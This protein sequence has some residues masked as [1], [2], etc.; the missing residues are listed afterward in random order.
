MLKRA[1]DIAVSG[2]ALV[3]LA[4][5]MLA[6]SIA[7][8]LESPGGAIFRQ[9]RAGWRGRPFT[10]LKFRTMR[11]DVDPYGHSPHSGDDPRLTRIGKWLRERSLDELPQLWNVLRG[12]MSLVG[13]RPLYE[14]QA[15]EWTPEQRRRLDVRPG[16]TG[17]AQAYGRAS[18]PIEDKI[19]MDLH[20][21]DNASFPMDLR[22]L[23]ATAL[24]AVGGEG[25][26]YEQQYSRQ[27]EYENERE[28]TPDDV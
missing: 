15:A 6:I 14:R 9:R 13:P 22:I 21:V 18:L 1:F 16:L 10:M 26:V 3:V 2:A 7:V 20:Y 8:R 4:V 27:R 17:Y 19:E 12:D 11:S 24:S 5:P 28:D 23:A 25:E